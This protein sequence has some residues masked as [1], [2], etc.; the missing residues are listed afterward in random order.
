MKNVLRLPFDGMLEWRKVIRFEYI[1]CFLWFEGEYISYKLNNSILEAYREK[2]QSGQLEANQ[3]QEAVILYL[4]QLQKKRFFSKQKGLYLWG[5]VGVGK[6]MIMDCFFETLQAPKL[7]L[8]F[9][10]FMHRLHQQLNEAQGQVNPLTRIGKQLAKQYPVICFDEFL[11]TNV[12]DAMILAELFKALFK[13]GVCL[14]TTANLPPERLYEGGLQRQRFLPVIQ[15]MQTHTKV[16]HLS[17]DHDY[18]KR[19]LQQISA[20]YTPLGEPAEQALWHAFQS[21]TDGNQLTE[22]PLVLYDR[23][24]AVKQRGEQAIWFEFNIICGRPRSQTDYLA[25]AQ[26]FP[27]ILISNVPKLELVS[28]NELVSF[29]NLIDI[30]YDFRVKLILSAAAPLNELYTQ[31]EFLEVFQRTESRLTEMQTTRYHRYSHFE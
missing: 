5:G 27:V 3:E 17:L 13:G 20:Y 1:V 23:E 11:V 12:A 14:I 26:Q 22:A 16:W 25:L 2:I 4:S 28:R 9:H 31:G 10:A 24:I 6:T 8:H 18:R 29:I 15:M 7:R 30:L 19:A 21:F